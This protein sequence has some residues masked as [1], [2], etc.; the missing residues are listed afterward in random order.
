MSA[1]GTVLLD[2]DG[3]LVDS[4]Y[5]HTLAWHR[6]FLRAGRVISMA[7]I[8]RTIGMGADQ[9]VGQLTGEG[10]EPLQTWWHEEFL[11][12]RA[13]LRPTAGAAELVHRLH[14][15]G[16]RNVYAT[17]GSNA[18]VG[19]L[20][21]LIGADAWIAAAVD[22]SE[23]EA[24]KPAPDIFRLAMARVDADPHRTMVVGDSVWDIHAASTIGLPC[25]A[26]TTGGISAGE[27]ID[28][29]AAAVYRSPADLLAELAA[30]PLALLIDGG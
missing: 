6:A 9:L 14:D 19:Y 22:S 11:L 25:V 10:L 16:L 20:R 30:S 15:A 17:S 29:G 5:H 26:L 3:T 28:A 8:H 1:A 18:D 24:S 4:S 23:V 21:A 13:E 12:L 7:D 27:L 2:I